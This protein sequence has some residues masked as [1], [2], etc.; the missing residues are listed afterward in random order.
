MNTI[1]LILLGIMA[2]FSVSKSKFHRKGQDLV[3]GTVGTLASNALISAM[4]IIYNSF[5]L[6]IILLGSVFI[7]HI[8][9]LLKN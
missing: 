5:S 3:M 6:V 1:I 7:I 2:G 4:G 9:R 8:G